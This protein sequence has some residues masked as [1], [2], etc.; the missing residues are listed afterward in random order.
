V[1]DLRASLVGVTKSALLERTN[2]LRLLES[3]LQGHQPKRELARRRAEVDHLAAR[4]RTLG[5]QATLDRGYALVL[6]REG[7]PIREARV[8]LAGQSARIALSRG[9]LD[10]TIAQ[11]YPAAAL[12]E[13]L[14][15]KA[16]AT[17]ALKS[18]KAAK[19]PASRRPAKPPRGTA[20]SDH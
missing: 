11:V 9:A 16:E 5:P 17:A 3:Q 14:A 8:D 1:D 18:T 4:L 2:R 20:G 13:T 10:A 12:D 7:R 19:K 6:D 15:P